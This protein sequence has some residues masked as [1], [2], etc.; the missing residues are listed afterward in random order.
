MPSPSYSSRRRREWL[1][2]DGLTNRD[3]DQDENESMEEHSVVWQDD[4]RLKREMMQVAEY[5]ESTHIPI[6]TARSRS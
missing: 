3:I 5:G 1:G 4:Q 6:H 2:D